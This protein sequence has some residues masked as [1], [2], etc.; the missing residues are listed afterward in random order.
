M[1]KADLPQGAPRTDVAVIGPYPFDGFGRRLMATRALNFDALIVE[2]VFPTGTTDSTTSAHPS[3][4]P[5]ERQLEGIA[6][7]KAAGVYKGRKPSVDV[8]RKDAWN[9]ACVRLPGTR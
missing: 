9:W 5:E 6:K 1:R 8:L 4:D 2:Q 7:A 3:S